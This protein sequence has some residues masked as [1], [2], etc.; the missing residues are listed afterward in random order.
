MACKAG[1]VIP[2]D[3]ALVRIIG[4]GKNDKNYLCC[5]DDS[6]LLDLSHSTTGVQ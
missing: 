2:A 1:S 4:R 3:K 6:F 5:I